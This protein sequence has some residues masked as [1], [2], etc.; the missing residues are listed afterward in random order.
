ME[1]FAPILQRNVIIT[2]AV[3]GG[4][5]ATLGNFLVQKKPNAIPRFSKLILKSGYT[6]TW[7]SI[8]LF[9]ATGFFGE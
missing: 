9:I 6:I 3:I 5:V 7:T 1:F 2:L 8:A 4:V